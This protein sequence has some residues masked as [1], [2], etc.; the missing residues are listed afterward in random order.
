M[1]ALRAGTV[2]LLHSAEAARALAGVVRSSGMDRAEISLC[3]LGPRIA[4]AAGGGWA[5]CRAA[6][7][8]EDAALLALAAEMCQ[9][10]LNGSADKTG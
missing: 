3:C 8:A 9:T 2:V 4:A 7:V 1:A 10:S 6:P 5:A